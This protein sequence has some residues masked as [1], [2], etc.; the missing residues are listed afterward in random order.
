VESFA[1]P[2]KEKELVSLMRAGFFIQRVQLMLEATPLRLIVV[3]LEETV[4]VISLVYETKTCRSLFEF[5][6]I[7]KRFPCL[8]LDVLGA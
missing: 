5:C 4:R 8:L 7:R 1:M 3:V 6:L 2:A